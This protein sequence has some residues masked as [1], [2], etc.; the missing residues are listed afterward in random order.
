MDIHAPEG[1]TRSFKEFAIHILIVTI[2]ILIA[3]GLEGIR[4][5]IHEH[6]LIVETRTSFREELAADRRNLV[7]ETADVKDK[8][9]Q[10]DSVLHDL[11]QLVKT[12]DELQKRV[13]ALEPSFY[14]FR[15]SAW[16]EASATGIL[17]YMKTE[18]ANRYADVYFDIESYQTF[19]RQAVL[20]WT[21]VKSFFDSRRS[22]SPQDAVDGEQK[23]RTLQFDLTAMR[24]A[25]QEFMDNLNAVLPHQ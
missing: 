15:G 12:P 7:H 8:S 22:F 2:G 24:H 4:E 6:N 16:G 18:E 17:A 3:L 9:A 23:L 11:P 21:A 10:L 20:D 13:D 25:D 14:Y 1:P 5:S 19:S